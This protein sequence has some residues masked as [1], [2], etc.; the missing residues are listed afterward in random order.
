[1]PVAVLYTTSIVEPDIVALIDHLQRSDLV[2]NF[3]TYEPIGAI[4]CTME[5]KQGVFQLRIFW[6][7]VRREF[8]RLFASNAEE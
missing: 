6:E 7:D 8:L 1:M 4:V 5:E 2:K 3:T